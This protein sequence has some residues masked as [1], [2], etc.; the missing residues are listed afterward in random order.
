MNRRQRLR[1]TRIRNA[2]LI[3]PSALA[4]LMWAI[5]LFLPARHSEEARTLLGASVETVWALLN[6]LDGMP[7]W[8]Q[9]LRGLE[10]LPDLR[11]QTRWLE[12]RSSGRSTMFQRVESVTPRRL[13]V[14][15]A[16]SNR[17]WVYEIRTRD[18][19]SEFVVREERTITNPVVRTFVMIFGAD[20]DRIDGLTRDLDRRLAGRRAQL[21]ARTMD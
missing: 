3:G 16:A 20:R 11:G 18:R 4:V 8:R 19:G 14:R 15:S 1:R 10:R 9:D 21:A 13:V 6:D 17:Q 12:I 5:G 2:S 7:N